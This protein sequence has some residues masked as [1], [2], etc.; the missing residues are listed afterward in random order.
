MN[1][2]YSYFF[3]YFYSDLKLI[4]NNNL[5][6][7]ISNNTISYFIN[8]RYFNNNMFVI[9][10]E[11]I[12]LIEYFWIFFIWLTERIGK[13]NISKNKLINSIIFSNNSVSFAENF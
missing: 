13:M 11:I 6:I 1:I 5:K 2:S 10:I 3:I 4:S 12:W 9:I 7:I 8:H